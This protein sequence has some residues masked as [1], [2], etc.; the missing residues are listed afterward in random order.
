[1]EP[2]KGEAFRPG[3]YTTGLYTTDKPMTISAP[4]E[5]RTFFVTFVTAGRRPV[6]Q[7]ERNATL[8]IDL[9]ASDRS[10]GRYQLHAWVIL[11]DH[12]H[13]LLTPGPEVPLERAI[14]FIKGG[15]SYQRKSAQ[16]TWERSFT[17]HR[18]RDRNDFQQHLRYLEQNPVEAGLSTTP[19]EYKFASACRPQDTD[20][21]PRH[22]RRDPNSARES[23]EA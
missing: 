14:Q 17:G 23:V 16:P 18:I 13:L 7:V 9:F 21:T 10:R 5:L 19:I 15:F 20:P 22:L 3:L 2:R 12:I 1:M 4:Q 6:F 8:L 11:P